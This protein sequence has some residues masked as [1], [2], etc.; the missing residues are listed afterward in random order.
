[1]AAAQEQLQ[2]A[3]ALVCRTEHA[4][5]LH[6][7]T[8]GTHPQCA[9]HVHLANECPQHAACPYARHF[10]HFVLPACTV[11]RGLQNESLLV[12]L[13]CCR[14]SAAPAGPAAE[15]HVQP[16]SAVLGCPT[17]M[18]IIPKNRASCSQGN[19]RVTQ[20]ARGKRG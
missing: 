15:R 1:M 19:N 10:V 14:C 16:A 3:A 17:G 18:G 20:E 2:E 5:A 6:V 9:C 13:F 7:S 12:G 4:A 8:I 11:L